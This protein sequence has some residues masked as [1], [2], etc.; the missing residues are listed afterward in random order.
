MHSL[1]LLLVMMSALL[2]FDALV[3]W[4][5]ARLVHSTHA[6]WRRA[7]LLQLM[8]MAAGLIAVIS[9]PQM[10]PVSNVPIVIALQALVVIAAEIAATWFLIQRCFALSA[11]KTAVVFGLRLGVVAAE[12][13]VVILV[14][15]PFL[16]EAFVASSGSMSPTIVAVHRQIPC[17]KCG[18]NLI[19]PLVPGRSG[20]VGAADLI[21]ASVGICSRCRLVASVST[22]TGANH[23]PD[24]FCVY[25]HA[26]ATR[27][28]IVAY[29]MPDGPHVCR[30]VGLPG[31]TVH[32]ASGDLF[33]NGQKV[34][35]PAQLTGQTY[36][37]SSF[38]T[39]Q[40]GSANSPCA[41]GPDE[42]FLLGDFSTI[43][44]D[45]RYRGP[46]EASDIIGV[47]DLRYWPLTRF[48]V[49]R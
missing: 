11:G 20:R 26:R 7:L 35:V 1:L 15:R 16:F 34:P 18:G 39:I 32:V 5:G 42:Y 14:V 21:P 43:A 28:D 23:S 3:F 45:S 12:L 40:Y 44:N 13:L 48:A 33:I 19:V 9:S 46:V 41:L 25:K 24:R 47:A 29:Q 8:T 22:V 10:S 17:T 36:A 2:L 49:L 37:N 31:E 38:A 27:W 6:T 4:A 30:L